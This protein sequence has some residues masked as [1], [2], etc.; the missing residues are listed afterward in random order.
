[1]RDPARGFERRVAA[2][3]AGFYLVQDLAPSTYDVSMSAVGF[4]G[5]TVRRVRVEVNSRVRLD[6]TLAVAG[7]KETVEVR[8][9]APAIQTVK[10]RGW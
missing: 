1:M 8:G 10:Q 3:A 2:D 5:A 7:H 6:V 9:T 4:D